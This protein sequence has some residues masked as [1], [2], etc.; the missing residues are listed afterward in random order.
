MATNLVNSFD[1]PELGK[2]I[3]GSEQGTEDISFADS[4]RLGEKFGKK[5]TARKRSGHRFAMTYP[6][7]QGPKEVT[8]DRLLIKCFKYQPSRT[9]LSERKDKGVVTIKGTDTPVTDSNNK[10]VKGCLLYTS[11]SPRDR[12]I[13][14]MPSSA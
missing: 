14:R 1:D 4:V 6:I 8:G 3:F 11:P 13:S 12:S 7:T 10:I 9:G 5:M 2:R